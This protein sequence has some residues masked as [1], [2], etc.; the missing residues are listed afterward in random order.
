MAE[1]AQ[2][3]FSTLESRIDPAKLAG[4][5]GSYRFDI[6]GAGSWRATVADGRL[7]VTEAADDADCVLTM[8]AETFAKLLAGQQK[9]MTAF[10]LGK[11]KIEGDMGLAMKLKDIL[12]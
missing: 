2:E 4:T 11:I 6:A 7:S 5:T 12:S 3:F 1:N 8:S 10:M 9:V